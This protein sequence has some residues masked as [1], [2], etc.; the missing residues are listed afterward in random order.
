MNRRI[1]Q[2]RKALRNVIKANRQTA[3]NKGQRLLRISMHGHPSLNNQENPRQSG[4]M[5]LLPSP[6][7]PPKIPLGPILPIKREV[8][9]DVIVDISRPHRRKLQIAQEKRQDKILLRINPSSQQTNVVINKGFDL[10]IQSPLI[11]SGV[12][13]LNLRHQQS[14]KV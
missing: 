10:T 13:K 14:I 5:Q 2:T 1:Q 4:M 8:V 3:P 6:T 11:R 7:I 9:T 12:I